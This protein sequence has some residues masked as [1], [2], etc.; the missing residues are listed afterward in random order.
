[1]TIV[2]VCGACLWHPEPSRCVTDISLVHWSQH[3]LTVNDWNQ[4]IFSDKS[5]LNL[6][7]PLVSTPPHSK[8][9]T[10]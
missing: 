4:I 10:T 5:G 9:R 6:S 3:L 2:Y 7:S 1:M 8:A